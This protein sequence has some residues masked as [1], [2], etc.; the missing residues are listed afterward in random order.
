MK[1]P[2]DFA[3][4]DFTQQQA[5]SRNPS[6]AYQPWD[7]GIG[8]KSVPFPGCKQAGGF[9]GAHL[10][11]DLSHSSGHVHCRRRLFSALI[12]MQ[13][14]HSGCKTG[15]NI[16]DCARRPHCS[17]RHAGTTAV[18]TLACSSAPGGRA[19]DRGNGLMSFSLRHQKRDCKPLLTTPSLGRCRTS[20]TPHHSSW[21]PPHTHLGMLCPLP[22]HPLAC[23]SFSP[24]WAGGLR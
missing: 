24:A 12:P 23:R 17:P 5:P 19:W 4:F 14:T 15:Q 7:G 6:L 11:S 3:N 2:R 9:R 8:G 18:V 22:P 21:G 13:E 1:Q 20:S 10:N 16:T